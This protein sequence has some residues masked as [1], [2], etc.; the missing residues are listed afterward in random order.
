MLKV[1][2]EEALPIVEEKTK[3]QKV[4]EVVCRMIREVFYDK[5]D[6]SARDVVWGKF[7]FEYKVAGNGLSFEG[8]V[9][10]FDL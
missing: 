5:K 7:S 6:Q 10:S 8:N 4:K 9:W 2:Q 3:E 1:K